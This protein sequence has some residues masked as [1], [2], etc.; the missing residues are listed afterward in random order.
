MQVGVMVTSYNH[1][2]WDRM[3]AGD[4]AK[5]PVTPDIA[6]HDETMKLGDMVEPLGFDAIWCAE[7]YGSPYS[8]QGN[9][10][11][12]LAFWAGRTRRIDMGA[13]V[14]A[15]AQSGHHARIT[16]IAMHRPLE[17]EGRIARKH[18]GGVTHGRTDVDVAHSRSP[19]TRLPS[20]S[21]QTNGWRLYH[22][23]S[24]TPRD[25]GSAECTVSVADARTRLAAYKVPRELVEV[26]VVPRTAA[27]KADYATAAQR[28]EGRTS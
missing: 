8:M 11:Q 2:D 9:P 23:P 3:L 24:R 4:Y 22:G 12:W 27:G 26:D 16:A 6:V 10:L 7:H 25:A 17:G 20:A 18:R 1:R 28:F 19:G 13:D 21:A 15:Q 14:G 5:P